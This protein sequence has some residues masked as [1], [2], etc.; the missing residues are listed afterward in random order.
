MERA[1]LA[2]S[3]IV[4]THKLPSAIENKLRTVRLRHAAH[5]AIRAIA[6]ACLVLLS[7]MMISM[8]I[9]WIFSFMSS[10]VRAGMLAITIVGTAITFVALSKKPIQEV[11]GWGHAAAAVDTD[12]SATTRTLV[13]RRQPF[14]ARSRKGDRVGTSDG[15]TSDQ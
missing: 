9:D 10:T 4:S 12:G 14:S 5:V 7:L 8:A 11:L 2:M 3:T 1:L 15:R 6:F 13:Y